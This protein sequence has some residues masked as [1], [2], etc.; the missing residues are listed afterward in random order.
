MKSQNSYCIAEYWIRFLE[1]GAKEWTPSCFRYLFFEFILWITGLKYELLCSVVIQF[2]LL[3]KLD[4]NGI[5]Y[6]QR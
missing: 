4:L 6:D 2:L 5:H 3:I 1:P